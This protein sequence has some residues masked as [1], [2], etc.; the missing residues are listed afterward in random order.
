MDLISKVI[1]KID[2]N[3]VFI[4][5]QCNCRDKQ[6]GSKNAPATAKKANRWNGYYDGKLEHIATVINYLQNKNLSLVTDRFFHI[7][8][9]SSV[10]FEFVGLNVLG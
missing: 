3:R 6:V 7:G 1:V 10:C 8:Q 4:A 9:V 5:K 2:Q